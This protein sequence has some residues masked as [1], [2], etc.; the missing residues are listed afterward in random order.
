KIILKQRSGGS[1]IKKQSAPVTINPSTP[2]AINMTNNGAAIV[3]NVDGTN[4]ITFTPI[5]A[6]PLGT[7]GFGV[8]NSSDSF[9]YIYVN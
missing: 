6:V 5:G 7:V 8:K 2:Y 3:V 4:V 9:G 1:I